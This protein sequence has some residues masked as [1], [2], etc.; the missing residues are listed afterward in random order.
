MRRRT[1]PGISNLTRQFDDG[2]V[3]FMP[4]CKFMKVKFLCNL[5]T[6][7]PN[8]VYLQLQEK[9]GE[10]TSNSWAITHI[11]YR[12]RKEK[13]LLTA[14]QLLISNRK[15]DKEENHVFPFSGD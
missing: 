13:T 10:N 3:I 15:N 7:L 5:K 14:G 1:R 9:K 11:K 12:K 6:Q 8:I 2:L 4:L